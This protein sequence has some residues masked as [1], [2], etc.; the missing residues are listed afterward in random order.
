MKNMKLLLITC[1]FVNIA[2]TQTLDPEHYPPEAE[3]ERLY[4][5]NSDTVLT[6]MRYYF[7][8]DDT[9]YFR[10]HPSLKV[11]KFALADVY[12]PN[13]PIGKDYQFQKK[14]ARLATR[15]FY[16]RKLDR[17][18]DYYLHVPLLVVTTRTNENTKEIAIP[19]DMDT[20][21]SW[22]KPKVYNPDATFGEIPQKVLYHISGCTYYLDDYYFMSNGA[23]Y[24]KLSG[25]PGVYSLP[26][27]MIKGSEGIYNLG[28]D[29]DLGHRYKYRK[30]TRRMLGFSI[31]F[32]PTYIV[33]LPIG[34][35]RAVRH[36][37]YRNAISLSC[38]G[39]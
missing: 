28:K 18:Y 39:V 24:F 35:F 30:N 26:L 2:W 36:G 38:S 34:I 37:H 17:Y 4:V 1:L 3:W 5:K 33:T 14:G 6:C 10:E 9:I 27:N 32:Y 12:P 16:S 15:M 11:V 25:K 19:Q 31:I 22:N 7:Y 8:S 20:M 21:F 13:F 29:L 23:L